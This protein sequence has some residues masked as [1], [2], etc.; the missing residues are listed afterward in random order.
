MYENENGLYSPEPFCSYNVSGFCEGYTSMTDREDGLLI[1]SDKGCRAEVIFTG[2]K[3]EDDGSMNY[4]T[5]G[6]PQLIVRFYADK[7]VMMGY[8]D[9]AEQIRLYLDSDND[10]VYESEVEKGDVNCDGLIDAVDAS[11]I[12]KNNADIVSDE[13]S[14][15]VILN[16]YIDNEYG[17]INGDGL[18]DAVDASLILVRNAELAG[19]DES[20]YSLQKHDL[21]FVRFDKV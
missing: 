3:L 10:D 20:C 5:S 6:I 14:G 15:K 21:A 7:N 19:L 9:A 8:D 12:L 11:V 2:M 17:D 4:Y 1:E 16:G 13:S 18:I